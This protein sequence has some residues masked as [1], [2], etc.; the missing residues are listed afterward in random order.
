MAVRFIAAL[1]LILSLSTFASAQT[2]S[3]SAPSDDAL[4]LVR[5]DFSNDL[6]STRPATAPTTSAITRPASSPATLPTRQ[7][8]STATKPSASQASQPTQ[9][10]STSKPTP[11][12]AT[13][14]KIDPTVQR[15][16]EHGLELLA[17]GTIVPARTELSEAFFSGKLDP[18]RYQRALDAL[19]QLADMTFFRG[20]VYDNDPYTSAY[21]VSRGDVL[22]KIVEREHLMLSSLFISRINNITPGK[23]PVGQ[24]IK[25]I[26]GPVHAVVNKSQFTMDLYLAQEGQPKAFFKRLTVGVG[27]NDSTPVGSWLV[28]RKVSHAHWSPP[29]SATQNH[30]IAWGEEGYPLGKEGYWI[31]LQGTDENTR[32][33]TGYGLHG[34][35][36]P[37]SV[38]KAA[39]LGCVRMAD[40]D[41]ELVYW[42]L[43]E[44][45]STV[46][47][48][49]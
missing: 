30:P 40:D 25:L 15:Q 24:L 29:P 17:A 5:P 31:A 22:Q 27:K 18:I 19:T 41:I 35:N 13:L 36:E 32:T 26:R 11:A 37:E 44:Q 2:S 46:T 10:T 33:R 1:V 16:Y 28:V 43:K 21:R 6:P 49:P 34:T 8:T 4:N 42:L 38:G 23:L 39:S 9:P 48:L 14:P 47:I 3:T 12:S 7:P 45:V 20:D